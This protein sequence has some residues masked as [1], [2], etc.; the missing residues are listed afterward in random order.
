MGEAQAV[1]GERGPFVI[2]ELLHEFECLGAID[3]GPLVLTSLSMEPAD[4]VEHLG[5]AVAM[6]RRPEQGE[7][8]LGVAQGGV[9]AS[10]T[11][12]DARDLRVRV[13][14]SGA[15]VAVRKKLE[16]LLQ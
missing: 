16:R 7:R 9:M 4:V 3:Q 13:G 11:V 15:V 8:M 1:P 10:F 14:T 5:L 2:P 12:E 6:A